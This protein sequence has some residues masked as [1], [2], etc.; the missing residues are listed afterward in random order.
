MNIDKEYKFTISPM[1]EMYYN[2]DSMF[3][4]YKFN[5]TDDIP[6]VEKFPFDK[7]LGISTMT[8]KMQRLTIGMK[9]ECT[10]IEVFNKKYNKWQ[11]E[12]I[13]IKIQK[14]DSAEERKKFLQCILTEKQVESILSVY[15]NIIDMV[16]NEEPVDVSIIKGVGEKSFKNIKDKILENYV[17]SD[18]I[19]ML[20]PYG[21]TINMIKKLM[22]NEKS[23]VLLKQ[24]LRVNPYILT[25]IRG[26]GFKKVDKIALQI[27]PSLRVS[28]QRV[29]AF[30]G[31]YL[32]EIGNNDGH[33]RINISELDKGV[34]ETIGDCILLYNEI[35]DKEVSNPMQLHICNGEVG[36]MKYYNREN[37]I[38]NKLISLNNATCS[39]NISDNDIEQACIE[40]HKEK[41]YEL[42]DEQKSIL[43]A[44]QTDNVVLLTGK[45]GSGKS[46]S[47]DVVLKA[48][49]NKKISM[50][51]LSAK[52][53][54]RMVETTGVED[55]KTIHRL[56]GFKGNGFEYD[57][58][59][60][61]D[62][63]VVVIDEASM[64]NSGLFL[65][66]LNALP[67]GTKILI[68]FDDGQLPP[69]GVGNVATD[70]LQSK[71]KHI[72][73]NKVHRQAED[74]GI[75]SDANI[76]RGGVNPIKTP[77]SSM[78]RGNLKDMFYMF[79]SDKEDI[80]ETAI[81]YFMKSLKTTPIEELSICVPRKDNAIN[82]TTSYNNRIQDL[83]LKDEVRLIRKGE[84]VFKLGAKLIQKVNNYEKD[85]VNGEIGFL[86]DIDNDKNFKVRYD[87]N[88]V[89]E[90]ELKEMD[91]LELAYALTVHSMQGSQANTVIIA[92]DMSS[93]ILLSRE[94]VYTAITRSAK[95]CL[96]IAEPK[97]FD[98]G[99]KKKA[100]KRNTWLQN[101]LISQNQ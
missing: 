20:K 94:L 17:L 76:I 31:Y 40:F 66:L 91:E 99:I 34:S 88:K 41:G 80:F 45:A 51:A 100:S 14:P 61:I 36:L 89:I 59:N 11:Y 9:Y 18:V 43:N 77:S 8:G 98:V 42:T 22:Q 4:V 56:L 12:P 65:S 2:E 29:R 13:S 25:E 93:Y 62:T 7:N 37:D 6:N 74:S 90:Y 15:P 70:L 57:E 96:V 83:L 5:T 21:V 63:D 10:A 97:A 72:Q 50:C 23:A 3:G 49:K 68:V 53:V 73:L 28:E 39:Y 92:I 52:A 58:T 19:T 24:K 32:S 35:I 27:T 87:N 69:I 71:F 95:R 64:V 101:L 38:Y 26:L 78:V 33:S 46:S 86:I 48:L 60:P 16:V 67:L 79:K 47:V 44:L 54:R 75:L 85:V 30:I 81:K 84:K 82:S 55:A 1:T